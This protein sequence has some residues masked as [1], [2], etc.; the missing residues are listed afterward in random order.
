[1]PIIVS[2]LAA[3]T[4][5]TLNS[6]NYPMISEKNRLLEYGD[7]ASALNISNEGPKKNSK[8]SMIHASFLWELVHIRKLIVTRKVHTKCNPADI[9]T[10]Q[11]GISAEVFE[12]H[13][14]V[15]LGETDEVAIDI[16]INNV[17]AHFIIAGGE[18]E[19]VSIVCDPRSRELQCVVYDL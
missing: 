6:K 9:C 1:M 2:K 4:I 11:E 15:I 16:N 19:M 14:R 17:V 3:E 12:K 18:P 8:H 5:D 10:K 13:V 7:N